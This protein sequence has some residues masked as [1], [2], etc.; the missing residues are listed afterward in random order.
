[1]VIRL[2][3]WWVVIAAAIGIAAALLDSVTVTGGVRSLLGVSLVFALVNLV[4]GP[5]LGLVSA[6]LASGFGKLMPA[7]S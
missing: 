5:L 6:L 4:L 1:M 3:V 7:A 2:L